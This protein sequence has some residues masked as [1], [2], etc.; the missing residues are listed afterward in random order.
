MHSSKTI[1]SVVN[2]TARRLN[3]TEHSV[4]LRYARSIDVNEPDVF[5]DGLYALYCEDSL[6]GDDC[7]DDLIDRFCLDLLCN[8]IVKIA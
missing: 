4:F 8:Q 2:A 1:R 6:D 3:C 7:I 5:G